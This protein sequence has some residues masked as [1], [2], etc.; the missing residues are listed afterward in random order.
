MSITRRRALLAAVVPVLLLS[1][2]AADAA[3]VERVC[4]EPGTIPS[5]S[6]ALS[7]LDTDLPDLDG[8]GDGGG[9]PCLYIKLTGTP[10]PGWGGANNSK[11]P[12][13]WQQSKAWGERYK[14]Y[15]DFHVC[16]P[17]CPVL[18]QLDDVIPPVCEPQ[19]S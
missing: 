11:P 7:V 12:Y 6:E 19:A 14:G 4:V 18:T 17:A 10:P 9:T 13:V 8:E 3:C 5:A 2:N 1:T 15:Y 16:V